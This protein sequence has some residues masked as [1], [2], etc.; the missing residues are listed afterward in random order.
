MGPVAKERKDINIDYYNCQT[1]GSQEWTSMDNAG[2]S[3]TSESYLIILVNEGESTCR[4]CCLPGSSCF[5]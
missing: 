5:L 3:T 1:T 2:D 4:S